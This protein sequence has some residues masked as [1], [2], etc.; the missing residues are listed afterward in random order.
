MSAASG[1]AS[2]PPLPLADGTPHA[3]ATPIPAAAGPCWV[4]ELGPLE[5]PLP[6]ELWRLEAAEDCLPLKHRFSVYVHYFENWA[7]PL[8]LIKIASF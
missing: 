5:R 6:A 1:L 8:G 7:G 2:P 4:V 3:A